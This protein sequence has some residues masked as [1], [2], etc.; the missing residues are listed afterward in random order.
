MTQKKKQIHKINKS[1]NKDLDYETKIVH[2]FI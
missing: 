1:K 2:N